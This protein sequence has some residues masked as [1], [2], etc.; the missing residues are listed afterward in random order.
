MIFGKNDIE[1][2]LQ[3]NNIIYALNMSMNLFSLMTIYNKNYETRIIFEYDLRIFHEEILIVVAVRDEEGFF[4]LKIIIDS[5]AMIT[6]VSKEITF[7]ID[8][9]I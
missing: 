1:M 4:R 8:I 3:F 9:N 5:Y 7:E 6:Q 2:E